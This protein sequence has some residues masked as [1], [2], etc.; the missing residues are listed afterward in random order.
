MDHELVSGANRLCVEPATGRIALLT[1]GGRELVVG[2]RGRGPFR[3]HFPYPDF[4]AHMLEA[5]H[6]APAVTASPDALRLTYANLAGKR[7][8]LDLGAG[9][10]IKSA[11]DGGF[12]LT[13][14]I[15]N[16]TAT[17][18]PQVFFPWISGFQKV[19]G[20]ADQ[21]TF[22]HSV[23]KP[24]QVWRT[25]PD[26]LFLQYK[27]H[28]YFDMLAADGYKAGIKWMDFGGGAAGASL[29]AK[30]R[31]PIPQFMLVAADGYGTDTLDLGWYFYPFIAP[32]EAWQSPTFV[33]Y[34]HAGDWHA[35]ILKFKEYADQAFTPAPSTPARDETLGQQCLWLG[36]QYQDWQD[37]PIK[38]RDIP[39]IAAE[40][41]AAGFRELSLWGTSDYFRFPHNALPALGGDAEFKAA[42][43]ACQA[44]GVNPV[45]LISCRL[46][47][48]DTLPA[49]A[50]R[51][52]WFAEN[53][54]GQNLADNWSY[55][56]GMIPRLPI[57]QIGSYAAHYVCEG[58]RQWRAAYFAFLRKAVETWGLRGVVFDQAVV[59]THNTAGLCFNPLHTHPPDG[60][61][62]CMTDALIATKDHFRQH[63][64]DEAVLAGESLW[65]L[66]TEWMDYTSD[67]AHI[68]DEHLAPFH[69][70][71]PRA[72]QSI[73]CMGQKAMLNRIFT[74]GYW[75]ELYMEEGAA[76]LSN[77]PELTAYLQTLAAFKKR[78]SR[79]FNQRDVYLHDMYVQAKPAEGAW[80][81][82]HRSGNETLVLATHKDGAPTSLEL[83]LDVAGILGAGRRRAQVW[84]R[85][86]QSLGET[87][88]SGEITLRLDIPA[89]DFVAIHLR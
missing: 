63:F 54:A 39:A 8:P 12:E 40:A 64:G 72:R 58:S 14:R 32:G 48:A 35:G 85:A 62:Q 4:Q 84:S 16:N 28:P 68:G 60:Q 23:F 88:G 73:K 10:T 87:S 86:L 9:L 27:A 25:P 24:W 3:L 83:K 71:F 81:R 45:P 89:D 65:D 74:A 77:Y 33:L 50:D 15:K 5:H 34:P 70:A 26:H 53:V 36:W 42:V 43:E 38:Y 56:P 76:R 17:P 78:F 37:T 80:V 2:A 44:I 51:R 66:C 82:V 20:D 75:I 49:D 22:G 6:T 79:F 29:F 1:A 67:W 57:R 7:G 31:E 19:D 61:Q 30:Q 55:D 52:E 21:V 11:G 69:M 13:L 46:I 41:R 59:T 47:N 18:I